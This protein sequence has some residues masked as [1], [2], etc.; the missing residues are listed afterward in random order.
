MTWGTVIKAKLT[1]SQTLT[2]Q[3]LNNVICFF[4]SVV[5][6]SQLYLLDMEGN[7]CGNR[8]V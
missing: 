8:K 1:F 6:T 4:T 2:D 3:Q 7:S 5:G